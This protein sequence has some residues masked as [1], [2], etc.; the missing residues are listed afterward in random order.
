MPTGTKLV[1][2]LAVLALTLGV[3]SW[4]YRF[5]SAHR[6]T[7]FW[8]PTAAELINQSSHVTASTLAPATEATADEEAE[9]LVLD[10]EQFIPIRVHDV[11][12]VPGMLL[13][14]KSLLTDRNYAW[15][16]EVKSPHW[17]YCLLFAEDG[18]E[19]RLLFSKDFTVVGILESARLRA[20]D[21]QPMA[22]TL[23]QYCTSAKLFDASKTSE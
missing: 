20:V 6:S 10:D 8:G 19:S 18:Q 16:R 2:G 12:K 15:H 13:L 4:W 1:A 22:E 14:R 9:L 23:R 11:T 21:C 5:E 7:E 3:V 17:H